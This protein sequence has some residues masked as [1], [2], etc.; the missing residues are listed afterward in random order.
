VTIA[1]PERQKLGSNK[2]G[3]MG[4]AHMPFAN[5]VVS[6]ERI[7][8]SVIVWAETEASADVEMTSDEP[9]A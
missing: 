9:Q 1:K 4:M 2:P 3:T 7:I 8:V 6:Y 5:A